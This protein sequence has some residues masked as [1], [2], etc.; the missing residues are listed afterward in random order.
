MPSDESTVS[1]ERRDKIL[2]VRIEREAKRNAVDRARDLVVASRQL[3]FVNRVTDPGQALAVAL[4]VAGA[5]APP[6]PSR[7]PP[8]W[9][10]P[11]RS[12]T[13]RTPPG[14]K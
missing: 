9:R 14:G 13:P 5:S 7:S 10:R 12:T 11:P 6:P 4:E 1:R 3:G 2:V 8:A